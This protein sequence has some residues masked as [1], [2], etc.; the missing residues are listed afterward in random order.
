MTIQEVARRLGRLG[1]HAQG[2]GGTVAR[3]DRQLLGLESDGPLR[4]LDDVANDTMLDIYAELTNILGQDKID[5]WADIFSEIWD[6]EGP[7]GFG[8]YSASLWMHGKVPVPRAH[9]IAVSAIYQRQIREVATR[10]AVLGFDVPSVDGLPESAAIAD[11]MLASRNLDSM[12]PWLV[13]DQEVSLPHLVRV[14]GTLRWTV[15]AV[16]ERLSA[17]G[18]SVR[19]RAADLPEHVS[20]TDLALISH[21]LGQ[22]RESLI[23]TSTNGKWLEENKEVTSGHLVRAAVAMG[24]TVQQVAERLEQLGYQVSPVREFSS[25]GAYLRAMEAHKAHTAGREDAASAG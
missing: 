22:K 14:A 9:L 5:P 10:L 7:E 23:R 24:M 17:L 3:G 12:P 16:V 11:V 4:N 18:Y 6:A 13:D 8:A 25:P 20:P 19:A 2:A 15:P 21:D 1:Y